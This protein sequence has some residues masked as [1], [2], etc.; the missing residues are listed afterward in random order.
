MKK[1]I[2]SIGIITAAYVLLLPVYLPAQTYVINGSAVDQGND[3]FLLTPA[4]TTQ[5]GSVWSQNKIDLSFDF[6]IQATLNLGANDGGA[7]GIAFVLQPLCTGLGSSG[8]GLGYQGINPSV[9]V[10]Y[11]T[12]IN[13]E[14][15]DPFQDHMSIQQNGST[16]HLAPSMLAGLALLPNIENNAD[17]TTVISGTRPCSRFRYFLTEW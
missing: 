12:W 5:A 4:L 3:C 6:E 16:V 14:N 11:D 17:H 9:A 2:T 15:N 8:G 13:S 7:D 10:E 1:L